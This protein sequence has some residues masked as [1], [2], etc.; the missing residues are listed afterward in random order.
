MVL[1]PCLRGLVERKPGFE[2][3]FSVFVFGEWLRRLASGGEGY[4]KV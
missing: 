3:S 2:G 1:S 4:E